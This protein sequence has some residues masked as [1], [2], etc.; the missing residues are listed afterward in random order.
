MEIELVKSG[1]RCWS[2]NNAHNRSTT[3]HMGKAL[4]IHMVYNNPKITVAN[5][6]D[7]ARE[8]MIKYCNAYYR[9]DVKNVI[10]LE[11]GNRV[12]ISTDKAIASTWVH[13]DVRSFELDSLKDEYFAKSVEQVNGLSMRSLI[14]NKD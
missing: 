8:V 5:L 7:D 12:K 14:A 10:S 3:N 4:D 13:F 1:Y 11:V 2:D 6:C 9:W